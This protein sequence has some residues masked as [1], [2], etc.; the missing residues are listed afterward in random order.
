M[1]ELGTPELTVNQIEELC[2]ITEKTAREHVMS[3]VA[4]K[5]IDSLNGSVEAISTKQL[6]LEVDGGV[7]LFP[8]VKS[9]NLQKL[10]DE[11]V[12][13]AFSSVEKQLRR[14]ACRSQK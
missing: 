9:F 4:S 1:E 7:S 13:E 5:N 2:L 12:K 3:T 14:L 8:S 11:A 10:V 6:V